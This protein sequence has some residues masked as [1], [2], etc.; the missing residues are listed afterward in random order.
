MSCAIALVAALTTMVPA[1]DW[2]VK[3]ECGD[4]SAVFEVDPPE[5]IEV[6]GERHARLPAPVKRNGW[7]KECKFMAVRAMECTVGYAVVQDSIRISTADG[8]PLIRD[9]DYTVDPQW[10]GIEW[11]DGASIGTNVPIVVDYAYLVRRLDSVVKDRGGALRLKKGESHVVT[12]TPPAL[13][14]GE[15]LV[16]NI[17]LDAETTRLSDRNLFPVVSAAPELA[18]GGVPVAAKLLPKTWAKLHAGK[19][20]RILAWGDS[21]T[22][23]GFVPKEDKWQEQFVRR[24]RMRFPKARIELVVNAWPGRSSSN[25]LRVP[26]DDPHH[27]TNRVVGVKADLVVSE[28]VNDANASD[29]IVKRHYPTFLK[30]FRDAGTEWIILTPHYVRPDW[31]GLKGCKNTD[32]DPRPFVKALRAFAAENS[33]ALAD[34]AKLWGGLWRRGMPFSVMYANDINH[35]LTPGMTLFADALMELFGPAGK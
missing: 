18:A 29:R 25:F 30:A 24:L 11:K 1:G 7:T 17:L 6:K 14:P 33:I 2:S 19:N 16:G 15:E 9:R 13:A 26:P 31:M 28:F 12:P 22:A 32:D 27:F 35:P 34:A 21:V 10:G 23:G 3:V 5:R 8:K 20:V 4:G